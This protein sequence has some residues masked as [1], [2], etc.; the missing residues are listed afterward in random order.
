[1]EFKAYHLVIIL[2]VLICASC[3]AHQTFQEQETIRTYIKKG[4][5][6]TPGTHWYE[7]SS[8]KAPKPLPLQVEDKSTDIIIKERE[9]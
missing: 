3:T 7:N 2:V 1:M 9:K 8:W 4:Y 5:Q 6:L